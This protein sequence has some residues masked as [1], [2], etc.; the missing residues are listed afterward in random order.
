MG[1]AEV[2]AA[3]GDYLAVDIGP[4]GLR[5]R[6][7]GTDPEMRL[8][9]RD[10]TGTPSAGVDAAMLASAPPQAGRTVVVDAATATLVGALGASSP[11]SCSR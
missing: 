1:A 2:A 6:R 8:D 11:A 7:T 9:I 3:R 5:A 10:L 4:H